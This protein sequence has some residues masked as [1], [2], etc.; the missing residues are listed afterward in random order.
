MCPVE[1]QEAVRAALAPM[2]DLPISVDPYGSR[3]IFNVHRNIW[4]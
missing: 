3:V 1:Q 4:S 2:K